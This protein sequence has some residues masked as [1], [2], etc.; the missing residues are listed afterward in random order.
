MQ[1]TA[2]L[3]LAFFFAALPAAEP[4]PDDQARFLAGMT[5]EGTALA[6]L[7]HQE[8]WIRHSAELTRAWGSLEHTQLAPI[9]GW[10]QQMLPLE[11]S[12]NA[13][14]FYMFSGPDFL[15]A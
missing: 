7:G 12:D 13:P 1:R 14:L 3:S 11:Y 2:C 5:V 9:R 15:Y 8:G 6:T 4:T 10:C